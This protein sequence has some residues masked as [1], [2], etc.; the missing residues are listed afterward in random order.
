VVIDDGTNRYL[1]VTANVAGLPPGA[2]KTTANALAI[3]YKAGTGGGTDGIPLTMG[4]VVQDAVNAAF[5]VDG[6]AFTRNSNV[7]SDAL[8]GVTLTLEAQGGPAEDLVV[9]NDVAGT[10]KKLQEFADAYNAVVKLVQRELAV[11]PDTD[12]SKTLAGEASVRSLQARLRGLLTTPV[13][14]AGATRTLAELGLE[15]NRD[16]GLVSIDG[17]VLGKALARD[18]GSVNAIFSTAVTGLEDVAEKLVQGLVRDGDGVLQSRKESLEKL[19]RRLDDDAVRMQS[20]IDAYRE[21]L[22]RQFTAMEQTVS[23]FKSVGSFLSSQLTA[24]NDDS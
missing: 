16:T 14:A 4:T 6:I 19:V 1:S 18:G 21:L 12:R 7:V 9:E 2:G 13:A 22:V 24:R 17:D 8:P 10:E 23:R 15:S 5:T 20:K 11:A 3:G